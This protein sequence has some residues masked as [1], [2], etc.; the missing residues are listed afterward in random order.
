MNATRQRTWVAQALIV[1][2]G[3]SLVL[4]AGR[5]V[6]IQQEMGPELLAWSQ[7]R[8]SSTVPLAG[9]RGAILDRRYRVLAGSHDQPTIYADPRLVPDHAEAAERLAAILT[10]PDE[11]PAAKHATVEQI[12]KLLEKPAAPR[13]VVLRRGAGAAEVAAVSKLQIPG[14]AVTHEPVRKY[15]MGFVAA[16]V[17]GFVGTDGTG[18]EGVELACE[19]VLKA[20]PGRR[21]VFWDAHRKALFQAADSYVPPRDGLQVVLTLDAAIQEVL[22]REVNSAV[23]K[24]QA[25]SGLGILMNPRTGEVLAMVCAPGFSPDQAGKVP[26][27][28]RRNRILTDPVEPGSIFKPFVMAAAL[29]TGVTH[30]DE[31]IFCHN[32][33]YVIGRRRLNDHH[34][35]GTLTT[36]QI[37]TKSSNIGMAIIGQRLGNRR[38]HDG[39]ATLGFGQLTGIDL[40]GESVGLFMPF[41]NW[42]SYTTVSVPMGHELAV[43]PLQMVT[44]FCSLVN[45]G[46][47]VRPYVVAAVVDAEGRVVEDRRPVQE[48][49]QIVEP[50]AAAMLKEMLIKTVNEGTGRPCNLDRWQ[51]MGK[52]GTAQ[53][54]RTDRRGYERDAYLGSF[55]AA[56]PAAD[57]EVAALVMIRKPNR[58]IAYYGSQV[59]APAVKATLEAALAYLQV[60]PD[61]GAAAPGALVRQ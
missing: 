4:L 7:R 48:Y 56:A 60:P 53:V 50:A 54:P 15:P 44:A 22:E 59:A 36:T 52:T 34:P 24:F 3:L 19:S 27:E 41:Q 42:K 14:I 47:S 18:L 25:E 55:L 17:L 43:T 26:A 21:V 13:Y 16:H 2:L 5:L 35:Y 8:Q 1:L 29:E 57:P 39:L 45:G 12:R 28:L 11:G 46:R 6:Y 30:P 58:R 31:P 32:G 61:K 38:M 20:T 10:A 9:R 37:I 49:R 23:E 51:V 33:L 40:P